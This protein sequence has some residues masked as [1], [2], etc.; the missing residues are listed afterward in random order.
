MNLDDKLAIR[1]RLFN[2]GQC[3]KRIDDYLQGKQQEERKVLKFIVKKKK[4][5]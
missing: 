2:W 3:R 5:K 1:F 4:K